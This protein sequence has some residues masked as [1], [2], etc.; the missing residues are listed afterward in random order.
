MFKLTSVRVVLDNPQEIVH[1]NDTFPVDDFSVEGLV[2]HVQGPAVMDVDVAHTGDGILV[3]GHVS[4]PTRV[5]C[6]RCLEEFDLEL[7]GHFETLFY[8]KPTV[9]EEGDELPS[10]DEQGDIALQAEVYAAL[11]IEAPFAPICGDD[12]KGLCPKCGT[13]LN[14]ETCHCSN[15]VDP[16]HPFAGLA[17][18]IKGEDD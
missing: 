6:V 12:C 1:L 7:H 4:L 18:L 14:E 10:V 9:D 8:L 2:Y 5:A 13:N 3:Y 16:H 11:R 15:E 17:D